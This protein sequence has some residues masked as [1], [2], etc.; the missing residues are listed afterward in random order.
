MINIE[1]Q[2][3]F[4]N[5]CIKY[6]IPQELLIELFSLAIDNLN[7]IIKDN[8]KVDEIRPAEYTNDHIENKYN[9]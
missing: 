7:Y 1:C 4:K 9:I 3:C 5:K 6:R 2:E 8:N